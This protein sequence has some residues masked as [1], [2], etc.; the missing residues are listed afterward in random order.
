LKY[1]HRG[2]PSRDHSKEVYVPYQIVKELAGGAAGRHWH[3]TWKVEA[4]QHVE[5]DGTV[6]YNCSYKCCWTQWKSWK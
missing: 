3:E 1:I 5:F 6:G 2:E 4:G